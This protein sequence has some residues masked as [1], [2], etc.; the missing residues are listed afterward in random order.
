MRRK[1]LVILITVFLTSHVSATVLGTFQYD[2]TQ[3]TSGDPVEYRV[4]L[5]NLGDEDLNVEIEA[6]QD[7]NISL[8]YEEEIEIPPSDISSNPGDGRWY[9][10]GNGS[11]TEVKVYSFDAGSRNFRN[12][13]FQMTFSAYSASNSSSG[14]FQNIIQER[15]YK[16]T[17]LNST[18]REGLLE[19]KEQE[20][21]EKVGDQAK[22]ITIEDQ[23]D[24]NSSK[25]KQDNREKNR[26]GGLNPWIGVG[27][28]ISLT[29]LAKVLLL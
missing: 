28:L 1:A 8:N 6:S 29:Y 25:P 3:S 22:N 13:T 23:K 19:F 17:L 16:F 24:I 18:Y 7:Q 14:G 10:L 26:S 21:D 15:S 2:S 4:G 27:A 9:S 20:Q 12:R 5:V 11:Y